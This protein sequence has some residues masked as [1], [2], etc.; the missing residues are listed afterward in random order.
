MIDRLRGV[1]RVARVLKPLEAFLRIE[2]ASGLLLLGATLGALL[3]ANSPWSESYRFVWHAELSHLVVND[4][5]MTLFFLVVGLEIRRE[6]H[7]GALSTL[8]TAALPLVA[9]LGGV[10]VPAALYLLLNARF[11]THTGWAVPTAT[12]IAF[13]VGALALLGKRVSPAVRAV[14]LA[15]AIADDVAA[16]LVIAFFYVDGVA[17]AGLALAAVGVAALLALRRRATSRSLAYF[18]A[19]AVLWAGLFGAGLHPVLAGVITG[20]AMPSAPANAIEKRL[21]PLVAYGVM[22]L[23]ALANAG[24]T[25]AGL[26]VSNAMSA[27]L[28][29][30]IVL[31][32]VV[33]KPIGIVAATAAGVRLGW[34]Q[35][36]PGVTLRDLVL[37]GCLAG[38]GF[39]M[40]IF[41]ATLAFRDPAL[42]AAAKLAV[43]AASALAATTAFTLG[44]ALKK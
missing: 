15:L 5:L 19:G 8:R 26:D 30:G 39:T 22:P 38:I 23:F 33:G 34:C 1:N 27:S 10:I 17:P 12:D 21:H 31:G 20:L 37:M 11:E 29:V 4:G 2:A 43:I 35:L 24:I 9:A 14:L 40:S 6:L 44:R 42:L 25:F 13:A 28:V 41:I 32:L 3:W 36:P 18:A 16:I 7:D